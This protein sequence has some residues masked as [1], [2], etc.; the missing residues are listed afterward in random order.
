MG[1]KNVGATYLPTFPLPQGLVFRTN[2]NENFISEE[3]AFE[4]GGVIAPNAQT[5]DSSP[6]ASLRMPA[7]V[8][9]P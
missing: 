6:S 3:R 7:A 9:R 4:S 5:P 2:G 8:K 1:R